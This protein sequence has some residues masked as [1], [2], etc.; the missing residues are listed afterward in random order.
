MFE[1]KSENSKT[2]SEKPRIENATKEIISPESLV[3]QKISEMQNGTFE[4]ER[5]GPERIEGAKK[6]IGLNAED[7]KKIQDELQINERVS[8]ISDRAKKLFELAQSAIK[9]VVVIGMA[10]MAFS[11]TAGGHN[12]F[13]DEFTINSNA[14]ESIKNDADRIK[15]EIKSHIGSQEYL[16]KLTKEMNGDR[17]GAENIQKD[18]LSYLDSVASFFVNDVNRSYAAEVLR[19]SDNLNPSIPQWLIKMIGNEG[20]KGFYNSLDHKIFLTDGSNNETARH[21]FLH[22]STKSNFS[23]TKE[24]GKILSDSYKPLKN[25]NDEYFSKSTERLVRKQQL[26]HEM[27]V[28]GIK[29]YGEK[30]TPEHYSKLMKFYNEKKLSSGSKQFIKTTKPEYFEKIF[31]EIADNEDKRDASSHNVV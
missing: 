27:E 4:L 16:E 5:N 17:Q 25:E 2:E 15:N 26:D 6:S 1:A 14:L 9:K 7:V 31:N 12:E 8:G 18:R 20:M 24:A 19:I 29:K 10:T 3:K 13:N 22:A 28:L 23:I 21:E 30:F 11:G